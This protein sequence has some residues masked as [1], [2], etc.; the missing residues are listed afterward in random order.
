MWIITVAFALLLVIIFKLFDMQSNL[1]ENNKNMWTVK[2][3]FLKRYFNRREII[4]L[5]KKNNLKSIQLLNEISLK[6][7]MKEKTFFIN[8]KVERD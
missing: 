3:I 8:L 2:R 5:I 1:K 6:I 4:W 7:K